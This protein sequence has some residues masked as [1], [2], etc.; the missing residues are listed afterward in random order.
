M[1]GR[2]RKGRRTKDLISSLRKGDIALISHRDLDLVAA[3]G[4]AA[5][6]VA[7]VLNDQEFI[8]GRYP[9]LGPGYLLD[10]NIKLYDCVPGEL[11][12]VADGAQVSIDENHV[13]TAGQQRFRLDHPLTRERADQ[14]LAITRR[15][16]DRELD[17]FIDN[18][19]E[20]AK[21]EK[22]LIL[23]LKDLPPLET[24]IWGRP[25]VVVVRGR[26]YKRD[27]QAIMH[28]IRENRPVLIGVD[29]G[30]D[31]LL[32]NG[33]KPDIVVGDMDSISDKALHCRCERIVHAYSDGRA[34]GLE[35]L[36][37]LGLKATVFAAPGTSED[38]A[39]LLAAGK[40]AD[41]IVAVGAH[42]SMIDFL[43]KGRPGMASTFLTRLKIGDKL[44]DARGLSKLYQGR[45]TVG[46]AVALFAAAM[47]PV[48][49]LLYGSPGFRHLMYL[50][51]YKL[52]NA[53]GG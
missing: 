32:E 47:M 13:L 19:L 36:N 18:T 38:V 34:P 9:N 29:G 14:L 15:N 44:V 51:L 20:Y 43:E 30:A 46:W 52:S 41:L 45:M 33:L 21:R 27:L 37:K 40:G 22:E 8:S 53:V 16:L 3:E 50:L 23:G 24:P 42:S 28:Y 25:V 11:W 6:G 4:L 1:K 49:A 17:K 5:R 12:S 48:V 26:G 39:L 10:R 2:L 35:R 7:V 31:A